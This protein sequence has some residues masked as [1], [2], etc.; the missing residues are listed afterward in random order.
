MAITPIIL[1]RL[2]GATLLPVLLSAIFYYTEIRTGFKK[3]PN[4]LKQII[5]GASFGGVA[6]LATEYGIDLNGAIISVRN[7]APLS[8]GLIFGWPAGLIAG[9][10]GG[11]QRWFSDAGEF[12]R[13]ACTI[14]TILAGFLGAAVRKFMMSNVNTSWIYGIAV[15]VISE[16]FC[17]LL[18]F[19]TNAEDIDKAFAIVESGV[20]PMIIFN[21]L[22]TVLS[23][24]VISGIGKYF[25]VK[26]DIQEKKS[27]SVVQLFQR[28]LL[29]CVVLGFLTTYIFSRDFQTNVAYVTVDQTLRASLE[30][31]ENDI[32]DVSDRN[33]LE[34]TRR[35]KGRLPEKLS[36]YNLHLLAMDYDVS[37]I[38]IVDESGIIIASS[39][40]NRKGF[41]M[42]S[43]KQADE[44]MCLVEGEEEFVQDYQ[45]ISLSEDIYRKYA[46]VAL[47][48]GGFLQV[49]YDSTLFY[50]QLREE[51]QYA[52]QNRRVGQSGYFIICDGNGVIVSDKDGYQ[53]QHASV[54]MTDASFERITETRYTGTVN[55]VPSFMMHS[56]TEGYYIIAII[57]E[58]EAMF[59]S[60]LS[61]YMLAF[62]EVIVF[63]ALFI[64]VYIVI[65]KLIVNN[66]KKINS[67]LSE[68]ADGNLDEVVNVRGCKE[69][70]ELSDDINSTVSTLKRYIGEA[71]ERFAK[72][73]EIAKMIQHSSLPSI[74]PP[75][76]NCKDFSIFAS[77]D[78]AKEVGGDF[79][80][81]Y[82]LNDR[83]LA[84]VIADVS[85]KG[86]PG[87]MFMMTAK[88]LIKGHAESGLSV[89]EIFTVVNAEL[90]ENNEADMFVTAWM[91]IIDLETGIVEYA[92]AGHNPPAI[93]RNNGKYVYLHGRP[94][95]VLG[96]M[97]GIKYKKHELKLEMGDE[98]YL[99]T[100]G[101]TEAHNEENELFGE[102]RLLESLDSSA[103][104]SVD[105]IC[106]KVLS[107]VNAFV[108]EAD[109]FDD[110]TMLC[111]R[112]SVLT[113][114]TFTTS[115]CMESVPKVA[116]FVENTLGIFDVSPALT[117]KLL[118][119]VDEI[120]SNI[121][122][123]SGAMFAEVTVSIQ[124]D[125]LSL[126][127]A[128]NGKPYNPLET[129]VPDIT[130]SAEDREIGGLGVFMVR[131]MMDSVEYE[132]IQ[133][134][135]KLTLS[136]FL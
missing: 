33:L 57:S 52:A 80:D 105:E 88:T 128:D 100:D 69:F 131:K 118:V 36:M 116:E 119:A 28:L 65:N 106:K 31:V 92:N 27:K 108:G 99:Y 114:K 63:A 89:D 1:I 101:V 18:I 129:E 70:A 98:I 126:V 109:Q 25:N 45:P 83:H 37:E 96:G 8:A 29:I 10:I 94:N 56:E 120:Y 66:I 90:C 42:T 107:D 87:A 41:D 59:A 58:E 77:M 44:F 19:L 11:I 135:N 20:I 111:V 47:E 122:R 12:T 130:A 72:D 124:E 23:I 104:K 14:G 84:I 32:K 71:E 110:I 79:Y 48:A 95:F 91:G 40:H 46:G 24:M 6:I 21:A 34:R 123:Y 127:F 39:T 7:S 136:K 115:P 62:M 97:D 51:I 132:H 86:I 50:D 121:V 30:D 17:M 5:I 13:M 43:G 35:I 22:A 113:K 103:G 112:L 4:I 74:F 78:A 117:M 134:L 75:Y 49:G 125:K 64:N 133:G 93:K 3:V 67:A 60:S 9:F 102:S 53:G 81:F 15:S 61:I 68:I 2:I 38:N 85:G 54:L 16:V 73:L 76:P 55:G 82:L 26:H